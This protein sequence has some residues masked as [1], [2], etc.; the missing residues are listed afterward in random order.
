MTK[1]TTRI[2]Y[3]DGLRGWAAL[4]VCLFHTAVAFGYN[5][6]IPNPSN[7]LLTIRQQYFK[8]LFDGNLS[9][10]IFFVLSGIVLSISFIKNPASQKLAAL[11]IKR[12]P[13]LSIPIFAMSLI[14]HFLIKANLM[15]NLKASK[16]LGYEGILSSYYNFDSS[17]FRVFA[18][19]ILLPFFGRGN[20]SGIWATSMLYSGVL[21]TMPHEMVGSIFVAIALFLSSFINKNKRFTS[22]IILFIG[23]IILSYQ[24]AYFAGTLTCFLF[25]ILLA[26]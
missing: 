13:R 5:T 12:I 26:Y 17:I 23:L 25:G 21:W 4:V 16:V 15:F 1:N 14:S 11:L 18:S 7:F 3:L 2:H 8:L 19:S 22:I 9:V 10:K 6:N 20:D 24:N